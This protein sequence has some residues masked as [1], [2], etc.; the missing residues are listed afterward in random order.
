[1]NLTAPAAPAAALPVLGQIL[2][3]TWGYDQT[4]ADFY[5]VMK[6]SPT[7]VTLAS[8]KAIEVPHNGDWMFGVKTPYGAGVGTPFRRKFV[9][10]G[11]GYWVGITSFSGAR[12]WD[13]KPVNVSHTA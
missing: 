12:L 10:S 6:V 8:M 2:V 7:Q 11:N 9:A 3:S 1:M 4:N 13:G 5:R